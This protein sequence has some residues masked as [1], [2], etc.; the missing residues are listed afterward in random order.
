M[1]LTAC[2]GDATAHDGARRGDNLRRRG[3][4]RHHRRRR[5]RPT[6]GRRRPPRP[7]LQAAAGTPDRGRRGYDAERRARPADQHPQARPDGRPLQP[8]ARSRIPPTRRRCRSWARLAGAAWPGKACWSS[9]RS[10]SR[11]RRRRE[12]GRSADGLKY[13]LT[14]RDGLKYSDGT[15]ADR[16]ELRVCLAAA[17]STRACRPRLRLGRL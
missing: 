6:A 2:G 3:S 13:T 8:S 17:C 14:L 5:R 4:H 15:A 7:R 10:C 12:D 9:T 16:Q 1:L 11:S